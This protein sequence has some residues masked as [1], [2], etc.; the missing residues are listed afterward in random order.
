MTNSNLLFLGQDQ[1]GALLTQPVAARRLNRIL[2]KKLTLRT[3]VLFPVVRL[4]DS[5]VNFVSRHLVSYADFARK[6]T[7]KQDNWAVGEVDCSICQ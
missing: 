4:E 3:A 1:I 2:Q 6:L 7:V 5:F